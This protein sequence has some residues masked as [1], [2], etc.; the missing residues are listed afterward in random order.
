MAASTQRTGLPNPNFFYTEDTADGFTLGGVGHEPPP[1]KRPRGAVPHPHHRPGSDPGWE[2]NPYDAARTRM[3]QR[4]AH[5]HGTI[6]TSGN[7]TPPTTSKSV[8]G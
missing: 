3:Y 1:G 8:T 6:T 7:A 2:W 4:E 5:Q